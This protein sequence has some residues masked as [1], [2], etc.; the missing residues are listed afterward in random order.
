MII[1]IVGK[2]A[3]NEFIGQK[4]GKINLKYFGGLKTCRNFAP[5]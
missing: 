3:L 5:A 1:A 4:S 2:S